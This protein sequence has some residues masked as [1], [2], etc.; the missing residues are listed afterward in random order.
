ME[1]GRT[2][3]HRSRRILMCSATPAIGG[4]RVVLVRLTPGLVMRINWNFTAPCFAN[5]DPWKMNNP[6]YYRHSLIK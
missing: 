3:M 6:E 2:G 1:L 5:R 4:D